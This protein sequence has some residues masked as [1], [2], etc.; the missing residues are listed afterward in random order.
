[1]I[2]KETSSKADN[3]VISEKGR[4]NRRN[5]KSVAN[6]IS[7]RRHQLQTKDA[8][9]NA[10]EQNVYDIKRAAYYL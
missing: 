2:L 9:S 7:V 1:M 8:A 5:L 10:L 4:E 3:Y 6:F